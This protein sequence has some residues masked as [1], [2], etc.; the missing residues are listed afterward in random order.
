MWQTPAC[1]SHIVLG[2][3]IAHVKRQC[4][5]HS[6]VPPKSSDHILMFPKALLVQ[7]GSTSLVLQPP[8]VQSTSVVFGFQAEETPRQ[9]A[10]HSQACSIPR[11]QGLRQDS[12]LSRCQGTCDEKVRFIRKEKPCVAGWCESPIEMASSAIGGVGE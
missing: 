4:L 3:H 2:L 7:Q 5:H 12:R 6:F 9:P 11:S 8:E 1:K 10:R